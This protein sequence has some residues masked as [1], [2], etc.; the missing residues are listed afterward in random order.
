MTPGTTQ[1]WPPFDGERGLG[2]EKGEGV[3]WR[4]AKGTPW[5]E[6][7]QGRANA[8]ERVSGFG[9]SQV[10]HNPSYLNTGLCFLKHFHAL[11]SLDSQNSLMRWVGQELF[12]HL[13]DEEPEGRKHF[14]TWSRSH[15]G[16]SG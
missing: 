9:V 13:K 16:I 5:E 8:S 14:A 12:S 10:S 1:G 7:P 6:Q 2:M 11:I 4:S 15:G 3:P